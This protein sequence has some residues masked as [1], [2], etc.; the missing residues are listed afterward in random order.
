MFAVCQ[1]TKVLTGTILKNLTG[2]E[3]I[4]GF[5]D[6][7]DSKMRS[8]VDGYTRDDLNILR[9]VRMISEYFQMATQTVSPRNLSFLENLEFIEGRSLVTHPNSLI[10]SI[11]ASITITPPKGAFHATPSVSHAQ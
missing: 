1:V 10:K 9:S 3:E 2:C 7:Q 4:D 6:I 11:P 5:I 8:I